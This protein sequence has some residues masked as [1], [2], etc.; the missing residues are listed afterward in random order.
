MFVNRAGDT[1]HHSVAA[2]N[3]LLLAYRY[4]RAVAHAP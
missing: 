1:H 3:P 4:H 2:H